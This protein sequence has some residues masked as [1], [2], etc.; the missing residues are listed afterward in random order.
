MRTPCRDCLVQVLDQPGP[1]R[2]H[3]PIN[4]ATYGFSRLPTRPLLRNCSPHY[5]PCLAVD[6]GKA[7]GVSTL[8]ESAQD[9]RALAGGVD[10]GPGVAI[11]ERAGQGA[12]DKDGELAGGGG[13][14]LGLADADG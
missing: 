5:L 7:Q 13:E 10:V 14:G 2:Y 9:P 11:D 12:V 3:W 1:G 4:S 8:A 6:E